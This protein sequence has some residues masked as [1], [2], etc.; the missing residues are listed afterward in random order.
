MKFEIAF[1]ETIFDR[2]MPLVPRKNWEFLSFCS[3][4]IYCTAKFLIF[5]FF[6]N[7]KTALE[8]ISKLYKRGKNLW[9][10]HLNSSNPFWLRALLRKREFTGGENIVVFGFYFSLQQWH[11]RICSFLQSWKITYPYPRNQQRKQVNL[12]D[13][14][15]ILDRG[16]EF[17]GG[18][19]I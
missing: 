9:T 17:S 10:R 13:W 1:S 11:N 16:D 4:Y 18:Q 6:L 8:D 19:G 15:M 5:L 12:L 2:V 14:N 7:K 3:L